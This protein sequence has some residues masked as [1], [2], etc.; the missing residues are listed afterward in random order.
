MTHESIRPSEPL[1]SERYQLVANGFDPTWYSSTYA[2]HYNTFR[3]PDE[4]PL[5][6]YL[7]VG[8]KIGHDHNPKF[9]EILYRTQN[10]DVLKHVKDTG[11]PGYLHWAE[12][13]NFENNR[14]TFTATEVSEAREIYL[15]LDRFFLNEYY[16]SHSSSYP[17]VADYYFDRVVQDALSPSQE[18]SEEGYRNINRDI[19]SAIE[20]G[21]V[22]SGFHHYLK[23]RGKEMR[24]IISFDGFLKRQE[25][26]QSELE[27]Q[28][29]R[30]AL[31]HNLP[32]ITYLAAL[33]M[34][35]AIEYFSLP[36]DVTVSEKS[37]SGGLLVL[38]PNFLPEILFGGYLAFFDFLRKHKEEAGT[39]LH[40]LVVNQGSDEQHASNLLRMRQTQ[41][42]IYSLFS[43]IT[44]FDTLTRHVEIPEDFRVISYCGELH[45]M[46]DKIAVAV[47]RSPLFFIQEYEPDF[48]ANTDMKTFSDNAFLIPHEAIYNSERLVE[49]FKNRTNVFRKF[50]PKYKYSVIENF[51]KKLSVDRENYF[52]KHQGKRKRRLIIYGR[53]EGH[54]ARNHFATTVYALRSAIR[55]GAFRGGDWEYFSVGSLGHT[56]DIDL[57]GRSRLKILPKMPKEDYETFLLSGDIGIS[58]ITTPHPGIVHYQMAS[59]G[60]VTLTNIS[61]FRNREW[62]VAMNANIV[63]VEM[64]PEG[65]VQGLHTAIGEAENIAT[66]YENLKSAPYLTKDECIREALIF[67][68]HHVSVGASRG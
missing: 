29:V 24:S 8:A 15:N 62:L 61:E 40:L 56:G 13:G 65:I 49:F 1:A 4:T 19:V 33:D 63:P 45:Y 52:E 25:K 54:A 30:L 20:Q 14:R 50:G 34:L 12:Y 17:D 16:G 38:V 59:Y 26:E 3:N 6:F 48:H 5:D 41:P 53:P 46:A 32:G 68:K 21:N 23:V 22:R 28:E 64:S 7:R 67:L 51:V 37:Q 27:T 58:F 31:E 55:E 60:L 44:K 35:G 36:V 11:E 66:R 39:S 10:R 9:S 43:K 18:F 47:E 42:S 57:D 2:Q